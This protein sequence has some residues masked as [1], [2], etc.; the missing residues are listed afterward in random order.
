MNIKVKHFTV[1][2][3]DA[4]NNRYQ[5]KRKQEINRQ[6]EIK[7]NEKEK[8]IKTKIIDRNTLYLKSIEFSLND[9]VNNTIDGFYFA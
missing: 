1:H 3:P 8:Q 9:R 4:E 2:R 7:I 6:M 5:A